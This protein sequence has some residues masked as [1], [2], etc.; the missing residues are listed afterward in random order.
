MSTWAQQEGPRPELHHHSLWAYSSKP[1][2]GLRGPSPDRRTGET[3][4]SSLGT[5]GRPG[6]APLLLP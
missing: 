1:L 6:R 3:A 5:P 4:F 2:G